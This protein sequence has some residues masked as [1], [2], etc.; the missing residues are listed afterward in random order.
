M[1][2][3]VTFRLDPETARIL[4]EL[5]RRRQGSKSQSIKK[6]PRARWKAVAED[7]APTAW[8]I[9]VWRLFLLPGLKAGATCG[10][11]R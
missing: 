10:R 4:K 5:T 7:S 8:E 11:R 3:A 9:H 1:N 6:A 2:E